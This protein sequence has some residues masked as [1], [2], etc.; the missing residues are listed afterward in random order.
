[1]T[2]PAGLAGPIDWT[3]S[4][5]N[6][7]P[8]VTPLQAA[9]LPFRAQEGPHLASGGYTVKL[10]ADGSFRVEDVEAGTYD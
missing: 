1:M 4:R 7:I 2:A 5:N 8:K 9:M 6:L 10:E 3:F